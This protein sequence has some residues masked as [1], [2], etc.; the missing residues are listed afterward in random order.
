MISIRA[1]SRGSPNDSS[2]SRSKCATRSGPDGK[3]LV[4][5]RVSN[6]DYFPMAFVTLTTLRLGSVTL[7]IRVIFVTELLILGV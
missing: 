4:L 5:Q 6:A 7:Q 2:L 3:L 1:S